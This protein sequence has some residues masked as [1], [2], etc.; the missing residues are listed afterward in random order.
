MESKFFLKSMTI[1]GLII[2]AVPT[3]AKFLGYDMAPDEAQAVAQAGES[4][5]AHV[6]G[7]I[8]AVGIVLAAWGRVR[9]SGNLTMKPGA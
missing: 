3:L 4:L 7:L 5:L 8:E 9:A 6:D 2:A 1:W